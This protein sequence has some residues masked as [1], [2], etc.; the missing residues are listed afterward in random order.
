MKNLHL[1]I[2]FASIGLIFVPEFA[3][4]S[5]ITEFTGP[6]EKVLGTITGPVGRIISI[7]AMAL[8]GVM[9][10]FGRNDMSEG[11]RNL[12]GI[13]FGISFISFASSIVNSLFSFSGAVI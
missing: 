13:V 8:C 2:I 12:L 5:G 3:F 4:A 10:V 1:A 11:F 9:Y 6:A 7:V